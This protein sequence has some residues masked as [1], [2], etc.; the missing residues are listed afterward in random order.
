MWLWNTAADAR[1]WIELAR[2]IELPWNGVWL[3]KR[4]CHKTLDASRDSFSVELTNGNT[5][6]A[7]VWRNELVL[8]WTV[9]RVDWLK[10][11][12]AHGWWL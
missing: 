2:R 1:N 6:A 7:G 5:E 11:D 4:E 8:A 12:S 3:L 10:S 9:K